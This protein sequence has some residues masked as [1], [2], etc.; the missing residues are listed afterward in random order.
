MKT[1]WYLIIAIFDYSKQ[2]FY[3]TNRQKYLSKKTPE[4]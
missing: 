4:N 1:I 2:K 3:G